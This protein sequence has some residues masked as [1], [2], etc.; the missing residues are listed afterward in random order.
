MFFSENTI[1][2]RKVFFCKNTHIPALT[3]INHAVNYLMLEVDFVIHV[4]H[5]R[6]SLSESINNKRINQKLMRSFQI[7]LYQLFLKKLI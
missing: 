3:N 7:V 6:Y 4:A 2:K 5:S 1:H